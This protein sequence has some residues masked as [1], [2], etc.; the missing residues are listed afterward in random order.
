MDTPRTVSIHMDSEHIA[1]MQEVT[2]YKEWNRAV[3][4]LSTWNLTYPVCNIFADGK[5]DMVAVYKTANNERGYTIGAVW[6]GD[7][8]GFHS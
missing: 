1:E 7:H 3:G 6:H 8:Y 4:Y 2:D 5:T